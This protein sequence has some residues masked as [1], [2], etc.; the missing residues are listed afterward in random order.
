MNKTQIDSFFA[1]LQAANP[2][3]TSELNWRNPFELLAA[4]MLSAQATDASVNRATPAPF[5]AAP[6][7]QDMVA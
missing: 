2:Q 5:A 3:P 6:T 7:P 1:A 4:V